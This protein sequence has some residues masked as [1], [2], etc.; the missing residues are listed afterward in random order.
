MAG[1]LPPFGRQNDGVLLRVH[2]A[3]KPQAQPVAAPA[4]TH[5]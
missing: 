1:I 2:A 3:K 4:V 5:T